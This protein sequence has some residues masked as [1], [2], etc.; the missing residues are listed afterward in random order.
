MTDIRDFTL[1]GSWLIDIELLS[2]YFADLWWVSK[3]RNPLVSM[4]VF[5]FFN[6]GA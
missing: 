3:V 1:E 4:M 5:F 6:E 2:P